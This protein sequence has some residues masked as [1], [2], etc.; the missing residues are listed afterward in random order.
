LN[1]ITVPAAKPTADDLA[2]QLAEVIRK[3]YCSDATDAAERTRGARDLAESAARSS[4][5][6]D[7]PFDWLAAGALLWGAIVMYYLWRRST[8]LTN[9]QR[10]RLALEGAEGTESQVADSEHS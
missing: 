7:M 8:E 4:S 5:G 9:A 10:T 3:R 2:A 6:T 1:R